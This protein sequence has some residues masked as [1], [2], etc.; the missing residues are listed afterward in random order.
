MG[1]SFV[2]QDDGVKLFKSVFFIVFDLL[3]LIGLQRH[4]QDLEK[5]AEV[6]ER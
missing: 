2:I 6:V 4:P 5:L 3:N 1:V